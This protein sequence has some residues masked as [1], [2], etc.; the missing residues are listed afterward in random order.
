MH[1]IAIFIP[2]L[3]MRERERS[4]ELQYCTKLTAVALRG[5]AMTYMQLG[6]GKEWQRDVRWGNTFCQFAAEVKHHQE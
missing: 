2:M 3:H 4:E 1:F 6:E 5:G